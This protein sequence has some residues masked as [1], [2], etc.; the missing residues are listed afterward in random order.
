MFHVYGLIYPQLGGLGW[1][2]FGSFRTRRDASVRVS[3]F[4]KAGWQRKRLKIE[5]A[6]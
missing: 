5:E 3:E 6:R 2:P 4:V 1:T